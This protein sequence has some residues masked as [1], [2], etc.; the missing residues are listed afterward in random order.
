MKKQQDFN[1]HDKRLVR[2]HKDEEPSKNQG[3]L[4]TLTSKRL[5]ILDINDPK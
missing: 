5:V 3:R 4:F 1:I 2:Q